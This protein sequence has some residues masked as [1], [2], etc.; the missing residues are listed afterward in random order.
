MS[1]IYV[2]LYE[3]YKSK[4]I[5]N[6]KCNLR[7][8]VSNPHQEKAKSLQPA[9]IPLPGYVVIDIDPIDKSV[10]FTQEEDNKLY[11][12]FTKLNSVAIVYRSFSG[13]GY[14]VVVKADWNTADE[15]RY[16]QKAAFALFGFADK[17]ALGFDRRWV[18]SSS[19]GA[20]FER[21]NEIQ[22]LEY[23]VGTTDSIKAIKMNLPGKV[24]TGPIKLGYGDVVHSESNYI[25]SSSDV[26]Y[27]GKDGIP[28]DTFYL[29][30]KVVFRPG[31]RKE[32]IKHCINAWIPIQHSHSAVN[33]KTVRKFAQNINKNH[34]ILKLTESEIMLIADE[35]VDRY[36]KGELTTELKS[37]IRVKANKTLKKEV[38]TS[39]NRSM[40]YVVKGIEKIMDIIHEK[41]SGSKKTELVIKFGKIV[42]RRWK[43][44]EYVCSMTQLQLTVSEEDVVKLIGSFK[45]ASKSAS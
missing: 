17:N 15:Y 19:T 22:S 21:L 13:S 32:M 39:V 31:E 26:T 43:E 18:S 16:A 42:Q 41:K 3:N 37:R 5:Y 6:P 7:E 12:T 36:S 45:T 38:R 27:Y 34:C 2:T 23:I 10:G 1:E 33:H 20:V 40:C 14:H 9:Y 29:H 11:N 28:Y 35:M 24:L 25:Q 44:I 8:L 30:K 4:R